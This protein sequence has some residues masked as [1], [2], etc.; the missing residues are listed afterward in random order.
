VSEPILSEQVI[1]AIQAQAARAVHRYP[2]TPLSP[3]AP[4][5]DKFLWLADELGEVAHALTKGE[6]TDALMWELSQVAALAALWIQCE[7]D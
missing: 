5:S 3:D 4:R 1:A 2:Q 7:S 6:G